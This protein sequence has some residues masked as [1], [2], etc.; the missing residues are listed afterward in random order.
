MYHLISR[1]L[2]VQQALADASREAQEKEEQFAALQED[3]A[4]TNARRQEVQAQRAVLRQSYN[5]NCR[6][7][8]ELV[9]ECNRWGIDTTDTLDATDTIHM[10]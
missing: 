10:Q 3:N 8:Q 6:E 2:A 9:E 1:Q 7:Y 5:N 4:R